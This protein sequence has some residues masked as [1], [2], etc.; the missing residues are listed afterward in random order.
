MLIAV[1][2]AIIVVAC[3]VAARRERRVTEEM[4]RHNSAQ[5]TV[6]VQDLPDRSAMPAI[7]SLTGPVYQFEYT[8][9]EG[10][11]TER[12]VRLANVRAEGG[13]LYID[14]HCYLARSERTFRVD[15]MNSV[16]D[17]QSGEMIG[18]PH[19]HF[20][21]FAEEPFE[22]GANHAIALRRARPGLTA[23]VWIARADSGGLTEVDLALLDEFIEARLRLGGKASPQWDREF[24]KISAMQ[25]RPTMGDAL[26]ALSRMRSAGKEAALVRDFA[27]RV[28]LNDAR[29][30]RRDRLIRVLV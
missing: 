13:R 21:G 10:V 22:D 9:Y 24:A 1:L 15:R 11:A 30:K 23:L 27:D 17:H 2:T 6:A 19:Q 16:R 26:A 28:A 29:R 5:Q 12:V 20:G 3:V 8:D 25:M 14:T 18:D 4:P 7:G